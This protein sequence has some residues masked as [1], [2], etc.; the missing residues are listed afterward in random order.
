MPGIESR[1]TDELHVG[2]WNEFIGPGRA[3][4]TDVFAVVS[5]NY[6]GGCY[7]STGP[8]S[9]NPETGEPY[10]SGFPRINLADVVD[11]QIALL[12]HLGQRH[13]QGRSSVF[14]FVDQTD[15]AALAAAAAMALSSCN[16]VSGFGQDLQSASSAVQNH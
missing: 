11:S 8:A 10:G 13:I 15:P 3:L 12:D 16:T 4:D 2:W 6:I 1:W 14:D 9:T 7:G 5:A